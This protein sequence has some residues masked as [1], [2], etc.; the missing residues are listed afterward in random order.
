[1]CVCSLIPQER[2]NQ[3]EPD[4][5]W[6][7]LE[8]RKRFES[9]EKSEKLSG[10]RVPVSV[11]PVARKLSTTE[12]RRRGQSCLFQ[13]WDYKNRDR[14]H[15]NLLSDRVPLKMVSVPGK[16]S[17]IKEQRQDQSSLF[18]EGE[19]RRKVATTNKSWVRVL[20]KMLSVARKLSI[21][22]EQCQDQNCF[23][24]EWEYRTKVATMKKNMSC[25]RIPVVKMLS[26][27]RKLSIIKEQRQYQIFLRQG[28]YRNKGHN[29]EKL[30]CVR[31][32]TQLKLMTAERCKTKIIF[33]ARG[34]TGRTE[35]TRRNSP[36]LESQR[37][38]FL[39]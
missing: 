32:P 3:L 38:C 22:K 5:A 31:V 8:T 10:V 13:R 28:D 17:M 4:F 33:S 11:V 15:E 34:L 14:S 16:P 12:E 19:Y 37:R 18:R 2:I 9:G 23:F 26:V 21:I 1:V 39:Y 30:P 20:V 27:A 7:L 6:L 29:P 25:V 24:Q 35:Q 36:E